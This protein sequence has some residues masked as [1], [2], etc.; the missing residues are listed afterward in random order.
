MKWNGWSFL[1]KNFSLDGW[2][3]FYGFRSRAADT[4]HIHTYTPH[5]SGWE[6]DSKCGRFVSLVLFGLLESLILK[7]CIIM[8]YTSSP[9]LVIHSLPSFEGLLGSKYVIWLRIWTLEFQQRT[10]IWQFLNHF[11]PLCTY[12]STAAHHTYF[13]FTTKHQLVHI[14]APWSKVLMTVQLEEQSDVWT[15]TLW[16]AWFVAERTCRSQTSAL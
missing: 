11:C 4:E 7:V 6:K 14:R 3:R 12:S 2:S 5:H 8:Y 1:K 15:M 13:T 16:A 10:K 9:W